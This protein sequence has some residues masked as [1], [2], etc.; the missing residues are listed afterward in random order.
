MESKSDFLF[1][2]SWEVC[3]KVG[4]IYTVVKSKAAKMVEAYG[5]NYFMIGP[6]FGQKAIGQFQE[7]I[8]NE[9]CKIPFEELKK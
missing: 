3:N 2:V 8:P 7:E 5:S 1:E 4:G 6:Y 9:F